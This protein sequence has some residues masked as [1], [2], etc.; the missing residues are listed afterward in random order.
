MIDIKVGTTSDSKKNLIRKEAKDRIECGRPK[1][2][3][4]NSCNFLC[5]SLFDFPII[6]HISNG[7]E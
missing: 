2:E 7:F 1:Q 4:T 5:L 6:L 3:R